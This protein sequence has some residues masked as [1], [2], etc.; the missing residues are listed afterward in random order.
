MLAGEFVVRD[1]DAI[2][3]SDAPFTQVQKLL[4]TFS[5]TLGTARSVSA[6]SN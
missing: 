5:A 6:L 1:G 4:S 3:I 2:L